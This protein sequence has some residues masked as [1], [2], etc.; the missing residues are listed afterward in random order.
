MSWPLPCICINSESGKAWLDEFLG[1]APKFIEIDKTI[2]ANSISIIFEGR[3]YL[4]H[5]HK[6]NPAFKS[7]HDRH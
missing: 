2:K 4:T 6:D 1:V 3:M 5:D 7:I